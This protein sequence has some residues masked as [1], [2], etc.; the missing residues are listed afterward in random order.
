[1]NSHQLHDLGGGTPSGLLAQRAG[2]MPDKAALLFEDER[3]TYR[4][5]DDAV[6]RIAAG[7][8]ALGLVKGDR[9]ATLL[10]NRSEYLTTGIGANRAGLVGVPI[11]N[12]FKAGFLRAPLERTSARLVITESALNDAMLSLGT[13]PTSVRTLVYVDEVP[14]QVPAGADRVLSLRELEGLGAPEPAF[15]PVGPHDTNGILFTSGTTGRSKGVVCPNLMGLTMAKEHVEV[16][17]ITPRDRMLTCFPMYHGMAQVVTCL[18]AIYAGATAVLRPGFSLATFWDEVRRYEATQ[19]NALGVVLNLLLAVPES[20]TDRDHAV[21][22]V[23]SAPAPPEA[24]Y[25][26]ETRF[27]VHLIEGYGQTEVKNVLYNPWRGRR[28][29]SMGLPTPSSIVEVHDEHGN[30]VQPGEVGEVVYR[31]RQASVMASGYL[32]DPEATLTAMRGLWWHTGDMATTDEDG[33]FYFHDRKADSLRRRRENI[34]SAEVEEVLATFPGVQVAAAV[35][36]QSELGEHEVLAVLS[37]TDKDAFDPAGLW[38]HCVERMPRFMVPR[39]VRLVDPMPFTPTGKVRK[40]ELRDEGVT[41]D[42]WDSVA[43]GLTVPKPNR[44]GSAS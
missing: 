20:D 4:E 22:R 42:T 36:A 8:L 34:S 30:Q 37:V 43:Q 11:N 6:S 18:A 7:M 23:F 17:E 27:G 19:F 24:L 31:P 14:D 3:W 12:A 33:Y 29:G 10:N 13:L 28:V 15:P 35:R 38:Q 32:E 21:T 5:L 39:Y 1:M 16:F 2:W 9:A 25:R 40:V 26:F 41:A 44:A